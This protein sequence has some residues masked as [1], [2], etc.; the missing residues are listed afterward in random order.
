MGNENRVGRNWTGLDWIELNWRGVD[1]E[2]NFCS[3]DEGIDGVV[4]RLVF[5]GGAGRRVVGMIGGFGGECIR[6]RRQ[7]W[8]GRELW[9]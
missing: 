2:F 6:R 3:G 7:D 4:D 8:C 9:G 1:D 5:D